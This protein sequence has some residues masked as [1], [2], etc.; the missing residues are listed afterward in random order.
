MIDPLRNWMRIG[1]GVGIEFDGPDLLIT[2]VRVR[3]QRVSIRGELRIVNYAA[4]P[5]ASWGA[6]YAAFLKQ[7][8]LQHLAAYVL[9][10]R[11]SA[12]VRVLSLPPIR[13]SEMEAAIRY[14]TESLHPYA[15]DEAV[16]SWTKLSKPGEILVAIT[17]RDTVDHLSALFA[18]AGIAIACLTVNAAVL[19]SAVRFLKDPAEPEFAAIEN[20]G[21]GMEV[22]GESR[23]R[24]VF[25]TFVTGPVARMEILTRAELRLDPDLCFAPLR[26]LLPAVGGQPG[27]LDGSEYQSSRSYAAGL[28]A[29]VPMLALRLNLLPKELRDTSSRLLFLPTILL[30]SLLVGCIIAL[31]IENNW[32]QRE[33]SRKLATQIAHIEPAAQRARTL[34]QRTRKAVAATQQIDAFRQ[35]S[36]ADLDALDQLSRIVTPPGF[37]SS[38]DLTRANAQLAGEAPSAVGLLK[39][40]DASPLFRNSS[41]MQTIG[42]TKDGEAFRVKVD[43]QGTP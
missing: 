23:S 22:Y 1:S 19:Y 16:Y 13:S 20:A 10:P 8:E 30:A 29:A 9:L 43:R 40:L 28:C 14:Q 5:A 32:E 33:Y 27:E 34:E 2:A 6:E 24:A 39:A 18:E 12:T 3:F 38:L 15:E 42:R 11:E 17:R 25:S 4:R 21:E 35:R 37:L 7:R 26:S 31:A 36:K 41:F